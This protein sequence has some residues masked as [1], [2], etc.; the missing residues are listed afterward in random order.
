LALLS[1]DFFELIVMA[2]FG[3]AQSAADAGPCATGC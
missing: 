1:L 2:S 3:G